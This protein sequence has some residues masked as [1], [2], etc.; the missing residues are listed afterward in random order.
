LLLGNKN[1]APGLL[2]TGEHEQGMDFVTQKRM[3]LTESYGL[4]EQL[5]GSL[6]A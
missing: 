3:R 1:L 5:R 2:H 6:H 4:L